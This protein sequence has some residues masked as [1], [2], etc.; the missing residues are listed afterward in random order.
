M[1]IMKDSNTNKLFLSKTCFVQSF[2]QMLKKSINFIKRNYSKYQP[3]RGFHDILPEEQKKRDFIL[4][5]CYEIS[6]RYNFQHIS[7]PII[8]NENV[9]KRTLG[10][11]SDIVSKE[12]YIFQKSDENLCLRPEGTA[13]IVRSLISNSL[14]VNLP[15]KLAYDGPMFRYERPQKGRY[16]QFHQFGVESFGSDHPFTDVEIIEMGYQ[17][18]TELGIQNINVSIYF[19]FLVGIK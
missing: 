17:I 10:E 16:R 13:G 9:F 6:S 5:K 14:Y 2:F 18:L 12:M 15:K 4:K 8:E 3:L 7:T 1:D 11:D 19:L